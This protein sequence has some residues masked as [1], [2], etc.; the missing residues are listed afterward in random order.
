MKKAYAYHHEPIPFHFAQSIDRFFVEELPA[1]SCSDQGNYL[2]LK[3][4]KRDM[5]TWKLLHV[6]TKALHVNES[7]IGYAGLKDKNAT[8][9]QYITIPKVCEKKL[10]HVT[11]ERVEIVECCYVKS[12]LKIGQLEGN[13]FEIVLRS[14]KQSDY[15]RLMPVANQMVKRGIPN[16]FGYQR[17][18][19]DGKSFEQGKNI[20]YSG[21]KLR[22]AKEKLLVA[23]Y[24]AYLFNDWLSKRVW[25]SDIAEKQS[26]KEASSL[27]KFPPDLIHAL[28]E[29]PHFFKLFLGDVMQ[30]DDSQKY[31]Y[32]ET[33]QKGSDAFAKKTLTP[34][35]LL[36]GS[37]VMRA[38]SDA[39]HLEAPFDDDTL[40]SLRG[41]RRAAWIWPQSLSLDFD[42]ASFS[43]RIGFV[44]PRG[45]YATTFLE[46][47]ANRALV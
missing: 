44:L 39:R 25:I 32:L 22:G 29:Q 34:T 15:E 45:A 21:K 11:T 37:H 8:S 23:S 1:L 27:L 35:G 3:I 40:A 14:L 31:R 20:A 17:F 26:E 30:Q 12:A 36:C 43:L 42:P 18:G 6:L 41:D 24:Q 33:L 19:E 28:K 5:S 13:R 46:A 10:E 2:M 7:D 16:Y 9:I 4:K 47:I 38:S